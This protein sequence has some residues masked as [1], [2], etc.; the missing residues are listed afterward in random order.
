MENGWLS[1]GCWPAGPPAG[2]TAPGPGRRPAPG[3]SATAAAARPVAA[4]FDLSHLHALVS[5]I[6]G[7]QGVDLLDFCP[8]C[9]E[10]TYLIRRC[11][12]HVYIYTDFNGFIRYTALDELTCVLMCLYSL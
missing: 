5:E 10:A 1:V 6:Y 12:I 4:V 8:P 3:R 7:S 2:G 11:H 9:S